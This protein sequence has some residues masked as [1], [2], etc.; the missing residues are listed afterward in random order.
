MHVYF[1]LE[2]NNA[3]SRFPATVIEP[4][5]KSQKNLSDRYRREDAKTVTNYKP[6]TSGQLGVYDRFNVSNGE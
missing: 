4:K 6:L 2:D 3:E 5:E 1:R